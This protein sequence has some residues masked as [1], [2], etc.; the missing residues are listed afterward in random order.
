MRTTNAVAVLAGSALLALSAVSVAQDTPVR[1]LEVTEIGVKIGHEMKFREGVKAYMQCYEE[2]GGG[3]NWSAW[4]NVGGSG[5][6]YHI[7]SFRSGWADLGQTDAARDSCW[8]KIDEQVSPHMESV[9]TSF[10]RHMP[11]W[12]GSPGDGNT[13]VR[14]HQ[15]RVDDGEKFRETVGAITSIMKESDYPHLGSWYNVLGNSSNEPDYFVVAYYKDFAAMDEDRDGAYDA[16][17]AAA[18]EE[19]AEELW[20]DFGEALTDDWDYFTVLLRRD[21][22][23]SRMAAD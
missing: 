1:M 15:F 8:S 2:Q 13:V 19:R 6:S 14:L 18:G 20:D 21:D 3:G 22:A 11:D 5:I 12:S 16:V 4:R 9:S 23:L 7:V 10:A 17:K